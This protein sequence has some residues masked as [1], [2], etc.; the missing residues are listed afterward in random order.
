MKALVLGAS[1][2][3]GG[4]LVRELIENE[5]FSEVFCITRKALNYASPKVTNW[6]VDFDAAYVLPEHI[7][8]DVLFVAFGTTIKVA[9]SKANQ[10][11]I[12]VDFPYYAMTLAKGN[13]VKKCILVSSI[14]TKID[15]PFFYSR[16]KA[17][18]EEKAK[19]LDFEHLSIL[20]PSMLDG[21]RKEK[22][23]GEKLSLMIGRFLA[24]ILGKYKPVLTKD[25]ARAMVYQAING[26][27]KT[28]FI[29]SSQIVVLSKDL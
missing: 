24:P 6:I 20:Q 1:G 29:D 21:N 7:N 22:R 18:L 25:V 2:L 26:T 4:D 10:W 9:G 5:S 13:G 14:G 27:E 19:A 8:F 11:K 12:D 23:S 15:S 3:V 28:A 16:M 17:D